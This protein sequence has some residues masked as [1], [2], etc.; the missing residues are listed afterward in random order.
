MTTYAITKLFISGAL[1]GL[2]HTS[3][4]TCDTTLG[5]PFKV[6]QVVKR[7]AYNPSAYRVIAVEEV[8]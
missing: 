2:T 7:S 4:L 8:K 1:A 5:A 3:T 6:G